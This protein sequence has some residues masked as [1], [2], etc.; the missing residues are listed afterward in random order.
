MLA[1][2]GRAALDRYDVCPWMIWP[3]ICLLANALAEVRDDKDAKGKP[4]A[5]RPTRLRPSS[6]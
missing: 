6:N 4:P 1:D 2:G 3:E 5:P